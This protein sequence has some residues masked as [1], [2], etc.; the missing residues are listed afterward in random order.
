[1]RLSFQANYYSEEITVYLSCDY[2]LW[3]WRQGEGQR[4][5]STPDG[6]CAWI[7]KHGIP[8]DGYDA[9][10]NLFACVNDGNAGKSRRAQDTRFTKMKPEDI[11]AP[12]MSRKN[13]HEVQ[14]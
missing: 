14:T 3:T 9:V 1:M 2:S 4:V 13:V 7:R 12:S 5:I 10:I 11:K 6:N 8:S